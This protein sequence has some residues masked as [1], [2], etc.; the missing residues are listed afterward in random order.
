[1]VLAKAA[2]P[3]CNLTPNLGALL[4]FYLK[5]QALQT[6]GPIACGGVVTVLANALHIDLGNLRPL[7]GERRIGF[8]TLNACG[9]VKKRQGRYFIHIH[10]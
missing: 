1:M 10:G 5:Y 4:V 7:L 8:T 6:R 9:M 3:N 2:I